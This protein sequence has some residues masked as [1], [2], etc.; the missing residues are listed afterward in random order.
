MSNDPKQAADAP[1]GEEQEEQ[2][3]TGARGQ[4]NRD[5]GRVTEA[6]EELEV[7]DS[8]K[9]ETV[10]RSWISFARGFLL[11]LVQALKSVLAAANKEREEHAKKY[12]K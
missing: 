1:E 3:E 12:A 9:L 2:V 7:G 10:R 11:I 6:L 5:L 8:N 4:A